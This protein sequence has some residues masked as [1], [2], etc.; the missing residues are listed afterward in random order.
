MI[1]LVDGS[2]EIL[3]EGS[4]EDVQEAKEQF[5][6]KGRRFF[7]RYNLDHIVKYWIDT[8][9]LQFGEYLKL[10]ELGLVKINEGRA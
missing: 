6:E 10:L 9:S 2:T 7:N 5:C 8:P 1:Q 3:H 4:E